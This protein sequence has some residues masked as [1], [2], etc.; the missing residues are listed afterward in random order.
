MAAAAARAALSARAELA[1]RVKR[2]HE[3]FAEQ[4]RQAENGIEGIPNPSNQAAALSLLLQNENTRRLVSIINGYILPFHILLVCLNLIPVKVI[5]PNV[6]IGFYKKIFFLL[7]IMQ[8]ENCRANDHISYRK[9]ISA[10]SLNVL[11]VAA[12]KTLGSQLTLLAEKR[13]LKKPQIYFLRT[14]GDQMLVIL[15][16]II[17]T[18][19]SL[20]VAKA[21]AAILLKIFRP[22]SYDTM[23]LF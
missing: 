4:Q 6:Q 22:S 20:T 10:S 23:N 17:W 19:S 8:L 16:W 3:K 18:I 14:R 12:T 7:M 1:A 15:T 11:K 21:S 9:R 2:K 13:K 5:L